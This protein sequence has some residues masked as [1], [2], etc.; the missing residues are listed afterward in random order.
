[1]G[2]K[3]VKPLD[4]MYWNDSIKWN[5]CWKWQQCALR[6]EEKNSNNNNKFRRTIMLQMND[7]VQWIEQWTMENFSFHNWEK[8]AWDERAMSAQTHRPEVGWDISWN[9]T[10]TVKLELK[11]EKQKK[12]KINHQHIKNVTHL[13]QSHRTPSSSLSLAFS[14]PQ[15]PKRKLKLITN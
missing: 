5:G 10:K 2:M 1:M 13:R 8:R 9:M 12:K 7:V 3:P 14:K 15:F 11:N 4:R 6:T